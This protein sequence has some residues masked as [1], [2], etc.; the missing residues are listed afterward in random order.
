M[1]MKRVGAAAA[2]VAHKLNT[3]FIQLALP[4]PSH[5][6]GPSAAAQMRGPSALVPCI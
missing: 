6:P 3:S 1:A 5:P 2:V 4:H